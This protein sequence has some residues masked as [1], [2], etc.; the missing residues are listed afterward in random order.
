MKRKTPTNGKC[1]NY[2]NENCSLHC[3]NAALEGVCI[4]DN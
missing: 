2:I 3:P 4:I 1:E